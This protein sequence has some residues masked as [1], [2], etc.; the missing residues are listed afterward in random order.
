M[1]ETKE[2]SGVLF[3]GCF[4]ALITTGFA[5]VGRLELLGVWGEEFSLDQQ[6]LGILAG[7]GIWPFAFS[8]II[9]SLFIDKV[10]YKAA[11]LFAFAGHMIWAIMGVA[12]YFVSKGGNTDAAYQLLVVGSLIAALGNG[13]VEAFI[14]P[15]V[16]TIFNKEKTKWLNILHAAWPGGLVLMGI[17]VI[18]LDKAMHAAP[19]ALNVGIIAVPALIYGAMLIGQKFP[20]SER[21]SSGVTYKEM[22]SEFGAFGALVAGTLAALQIAIFS[23]QAGA[24]ITYPTAWIIG[25]VVG[26]ISAVAMGLYTKS[27]G[28][29][30]MC[31]MV[32]IMAPLAITEIGTDG[33]ITEAMSSFAKSNGF[34]PVAVLIYTSL[35]MLVLRFFAGP[36][37]KALTPLGLLIVSAVLAIG[38]LIWLSVAEAAILIVAATLYGL[39]K[40]FFWPTTLGIVSE[41]TPKG[42]ALTL[43]AISGIGML[44][45]GAIGFPLLGLFQIDTHKTKLAESALVQSVPGVVKDGQLAAV[46]ENDGLFGKYTTVDGDWIDASIGK[47]KDSGK[48]DEVKK[49][50]AH[51]AGESPKWSLSKIAIFPVFMLVCYIGLFLWFKSKGGYKPIVIGDGH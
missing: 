26:I 41:Q 36:I 5:F 13:A 1:S 30:L 37:V 7:I 38:G 18:I 39:G 31:I 15:V 40:T 24:P 14:N 8:I 48:A 35:I 10:G 47:L 22:L 32:I 49:E 28:S 33:W 29:P 6:Q 23:M 51:I 50:V 45:C 4:I 42:G 20:V 11:M 17:I 34:P 46:K 2:K 9:F 16:A 3:W 19:W 27:I 12:A 21:V 25:V 43:N 44:A